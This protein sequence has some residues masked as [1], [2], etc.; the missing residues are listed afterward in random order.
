[1]QVCDALGY[2]RDFTAATG[3]SQ[4]SPIIPAPLFDKLE[5]PPK[6]AVVILDKRTLKRYE[7]PNK[8]AV[9]ASWECKRRKIG[10]SREERSERYNTYGISPR[11]GPTDYCSALSGPSPISTR[12]GSSSASTAFDI[13]S[14]PSTRWLLPSLNNDP[15]YLA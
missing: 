2:S 13:S 14:T 8:S 11:V 5:V 12:Q 6:P 7:P 9:V 10:M 4:R 1:M 15:P 3:P